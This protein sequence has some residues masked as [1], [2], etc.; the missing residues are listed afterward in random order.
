MQLKNSKG[1]KYLWALEGKYGQLPQPLTGESR[2]NVSVYSA[3]ILLEK[4][5][6]HLTK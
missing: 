4:W 1:I 3:F 6:F 2:I 5:S